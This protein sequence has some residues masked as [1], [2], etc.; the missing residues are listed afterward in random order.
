MQ[1]NQI[2][3]VA[4]NFLDWQFNRPSQFF[5]IGSSV[6]IMDKLLSGKE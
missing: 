1:V 5:G 3:S 4:K 6:Y 2:L